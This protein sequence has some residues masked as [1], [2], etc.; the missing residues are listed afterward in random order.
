MHV[1]EW[2]WNKWS[3]YHP[4]MYMTDVN[5][6]ENASYWSRLQNLPELCYAI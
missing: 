5:Q 2:V 6:A 3:G 1:N 4:I